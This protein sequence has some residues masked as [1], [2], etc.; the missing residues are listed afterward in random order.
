MSSKELWVV[1]LHVC[2]PLMCHMLA[3]HARR[4]EQLPVTWTPPCLVSGSISEDEGGADDGA[5][6]G[7][8]D[9]NGGGASSSA[10]HVVA[11]FG[12]MVGAC[13]GAKGVRCHRV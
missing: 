8:G 13:M 9:D 4:R 1:A 5:D 3:R 10:S 2:W 12:G 7:R 11:L 6:D